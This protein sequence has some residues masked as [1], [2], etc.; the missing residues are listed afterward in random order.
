MARVNEDMGGELTHH[1]KRSRMYSD[2][3]Q[4]IENARPAFDFVA[5]HFACERDKFSSKNPDGFVNF[6]SAQN[7]LA[8]R[9]L[10]SFLASIHHD[11]CDAEYHPF[12]GMDRCKSAVA[13]YL[14]SY[15]GAPISPNQ[16]IL[17]NGLISLLEALTFAICDGD[18]QILVP[19]PVFPGL[20]KALQLRTR[21]K[22]EFVQTLA[23]DDFRVTPELVHDAL[24]EGK[25][26]GHSLKAILL[27]SP[28]NPLGHVYSREELRELVH[29]TERENVALIVD[30]V[31]AMS[32]FTD[33][34]FVS[35][36][37]CESSHVFVL[38]GVS[39]DFGMAGYTVGWLHGTNDRIMKAVASQSHFFRLATPAQQAAAR[40]LSPEW[41]NA[42][43]PEHRRRISA[44]YEHT[45]DF[46]LECGV[47]TLNAQAGL[48]AVLDLRPVLPAKE[49][50]HAE[51]AISTA[52][53]LRLYHHMLDGHR[54]HL[55]PSIGFHWNQPGLFRIC[56]TTDEV[57]LSEGLRRIREGVLALTE[58]PL[59]QIAGR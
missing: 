38:G 35:A 45:K 39:K 13:A 12:T 47:E 56:V 28:G 8:K 33:V 36:V 2:Y 43:L 44:N 59:M 10:H 49:M 29:I 17:G 24:I 11:S 30:E 55:S 34:E 25:R 57:T 5:A 48:C 18:D 14:A 37:E 32:C 22:V 31:Y 21:A 4:N 40:I 46:L 3:T 19:T 9:D 16:I 41:T 53:E 52:D 26:R 7:Y 23:D 27:C 42:F 54:V 50:A 6:G 20:V 51:A 1:Q 58:D 15:C